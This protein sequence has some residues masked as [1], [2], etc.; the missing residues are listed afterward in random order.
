MGKAHIECYRMNRHAEVTIVASGTAEK[1]RS[2]AEQF[3]IPRWTTDWRE[4]IASDNVDAVDITVPNHLH[5]E[6][7]LAAIE[8]GKPFLIEKP[9][10]RNLDEARQILDAARTKGIHA[11]YGENMRF[12]P[13]P[14]KAREI[15]EQGG[16]GD[17]IMVRANE[18]HNGPFHSPWFWDAEKTGGGAVIDMGIHGLYLLEWIA[19]AKVKRVYA[20]VGT[21]KWK[22]FCKN[23]AEDTAFVTL[24]FENGAM[25]ELIN[26]WAISGGIDVRAE[27]YGTAGTLHI[28]KSRGAGGLLAYSQD[29]YG[30]AIEV[31]SSLRPHVAT[32]KGWHFPIPDEWNMHGHAQ[33]VRHF[34]DVVQNGVDPLCTL[35]E[36]VR[37]LELVEAIY[38][39]GREGRPVEL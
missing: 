20:E 24:R 23:G 7:A 31:E 19:G 32:N 26:S 9:L 12:A 29:G 13:A 14:L 30:L 27:I 10:A 38:R 22:D 1:A 5:L 21:L 34:L 35:E 18:I 4:V 37:A 11:V 36:G 39:S 3:G 8:A 15:I 17:V 25:G 6:V 33:E 2:V 28:D 16:I